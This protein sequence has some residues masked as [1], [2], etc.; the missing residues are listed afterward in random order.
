MIFSALTSLLVFFLCGFY[1]TFV[2]CLDQSVKTLMVSSDISRETA[3]LMLSSTAQWV[4]QNLHL[5]ER[6]LTDSGNMETHIP[7]CVLQENGIGYAARSRSEPRSS[8]I[9]NVSSCFLDYE[10]PQKIAPVDFIFA[11]PP[12]PLSQWC[13]SGTPWWKSPPTLNFY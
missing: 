10:H 4:V 5:T 3:C 1:C 12:R 2:K 6:R 13:F 7:T 8:A 9:C 11:E